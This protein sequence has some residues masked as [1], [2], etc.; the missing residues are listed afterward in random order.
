MTM[1]LANDGFFKAY[2]RSLE[3]WRLVALLEWLDHMIV[4][5]APDYDES[6]KAEQR[7]VCIQRKREI[8]IVQGER[9]ANGN[10]ISNTAVDG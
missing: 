1:E 2:I 8:W 4:C 9:K 10:T 7:S 3:D 6:L 5:P